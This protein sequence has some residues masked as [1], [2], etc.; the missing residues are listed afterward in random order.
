[1][2]WARIRSREA[3]AD[4]IVD[5]MDRPQFFLLTNYSGELIV[6]K[7]YSASSSLAII[8]RRLS[9]ELSS[10]RL[11]SILRY[12][13]AEEVRPTEDDTFVASPHGVQIF[14]HFAPGGSLTDWVK[15]AAGAAVGPRYADMV[16]GE[17]PLADGTVSWLLLCSSNGYGARGRS[18]LLSSLLALFNFFRVA[19]L[20]NGSA[21]SQHHARRAVCPLHHACNKAKAHSSLRPEVRLR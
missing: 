3:A 19:S 13:D 11:S 1:M 15:A 5:D 9:C 18:N 20:P 12:I 10:A 7:R 21:G 2:P 4:A 14:S 8:E 17:I 16:F 6:E